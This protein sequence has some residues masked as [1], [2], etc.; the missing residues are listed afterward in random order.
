MYMEYVVDI[1]QTAVLVLP[2]TSQCIDNE[3]YL[4]INRKKLLKRTQRMP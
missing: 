1:W 4:I 3:I 2:I